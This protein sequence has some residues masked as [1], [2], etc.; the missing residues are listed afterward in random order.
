[1]QLNNLNSTPRLNTHLKIKLE[2][3]S[4]TPHLYTNNTT[5]TGWILSCGRG[6]AVEKHKS[7]GVVDRQA[8]ATHPLSLQPP[9]HWIHRTQVG[10]VLVCVIMPV[11]GMVLLRVKVVEEV[12]EEVMEEVVEEVVEEVGMNLM[13]NI[14]QKNYSTTTTHSTISHHTTPHHDTPHYTTPCQP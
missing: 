6:K 7:G 5:A 9:F 1:M 11:A 4:Q 12:V 14:S 10:W 3:H 8:N 13:V 2:H